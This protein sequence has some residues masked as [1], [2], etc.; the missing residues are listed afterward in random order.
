M[1]T[2]A[3]KP[4]AWRQPQCFPAS[5]SHLIHQ[6]VLS[7]LP[8]KISQLYSFLS[9]PTDCH[10]LWGAS[11]LCFLTC[12]TDLTSSYGS[13]KHLLK[14]VS[15]VVAAIYLKLLGRCCGFKSDMILT[16]TSAQMLCPQQV[17]LLWEAVEPFGQEAWLM[18]VGVGLSGSPS[19]LIFCFL[20]HQNEQ[21]RRE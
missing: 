19:G 20:I 7:L 18:E 6:P 9:S 11:P 2:Q 14:D 12:P 15:R 21:A 13:Q 5:P 10:R 1:G 16:G 8:L 17:A 4:E 3:L